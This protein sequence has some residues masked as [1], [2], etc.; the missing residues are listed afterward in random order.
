MTTVTVQRLNMVESQVRPSDVTD[1]RVIRAI[2]E[3][4]REAFV[5]GRFKSVAYMDEALP[6]ATDAEG[7]ATRQ[8]MPARLFAK[9]LQTVDL[10]E[11]STVLDAGCGT[12]YSTAVLAKIVRRVAAVE[13]DAAF[14]DAARASLASLEIKNAIV[15]TGA[16]A[17]GFADESPFDAIIL[18]G[19]VP[20]FP[21]GLLDQ[22]KDGGRLIGV[23]ASPNG[24]SGKATICT[25]SGTTFDTR[26]V[27]DAYVMPL[28]GF[29]RRAEFVL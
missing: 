22:L 4:A 17:D 6:I 26:E 13:P 23:V 9:L 19:S 2:G 21:R 14:A 11:T 24:R 8:L 1:R 20:E 16:V 7:R 5:P 27:F 29:A 10:A 3:V 15:R 25:R 28:P 12:G 18:G